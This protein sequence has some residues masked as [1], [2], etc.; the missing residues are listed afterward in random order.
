MSQPPEPS[1]ER[2]A[3]DAQRAVEAPQLYSVFQPKPAP[4]P[5]PPTVPTLRTEVGPDGWHRLA[6]DHLN[7]PGC[8]FGCTA[9]FALFWNA[10]V[11]G[12]WI[13]KAVTSG[14]KPRVAPQAAPLPAREWDPCFAIGMAFYLIFVVAG[15]LLVLAALGAGLEWAF[16]GLH[17]R[18]TT[19]VSAH[20]LRPG[21]TFRLRVHG[22]NGVRLF[23]TTI[24]LL[25]RESVTVDGGEGPETSTR[26]VLTLP[27]HRGGGLPVETEIP[28]PASAMHSFTAFGENGTSSSVRWYLRVSGRVW[29]VF[30]YSQEYEV[31]VTPEAL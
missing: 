3:F 28:I 14:P 15:V 5:T 12:G 26:D 11:W 22:L 6:K 13:V 29:R 17:G 2:R 9:V 19:E 7:N 8:R 31:M 16:F 10:I 24:R 23:G 30:P 18:P 4:Q 21:R 27:L 20:P 1:P 25:C